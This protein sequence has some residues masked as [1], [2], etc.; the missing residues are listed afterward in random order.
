MTRTTGLKCFTIQNVAYFVINAWAHFAD[1]P[2][3]WIWVR[4]CYTIGSLVHNKI[5]SRIEKKKMRSYTYTLCTILYDYPCLLGFTYYYKLHD[6][7]HLNSSS[8]F[9]QRT[10]RYLQIIVISLLY[11]LCLSINFP[12]AFEGVDGWHADDTINT[13]DTLTSDYE[14]HVLFDSPLNEIER[15]HSWVYLQNLRNCA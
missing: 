3:N 15:W 1:L 11:T 13:T 14:V 4:R 6:M 9:F 7:S 5:R 10:F 2:F 12:F 8:Y